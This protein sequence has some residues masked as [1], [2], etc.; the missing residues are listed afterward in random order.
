MA[1]TGEQFDRFHAA[2]PDVYNA[3]VRLARQWVS[4]TGRRR[5]GIDSLFGAAR[6]SVMLTTNDPDYKL[7]NDFKPF[8]ARLIMHQE[9]DLDGLFE[10]RPAREP[11]LWQARLVGLD[12]TEFGLEE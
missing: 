5:V 4:T 6:W 1:A 3:L 11:D 2:H 8:Y 10:L 12:L 7:R 9:P